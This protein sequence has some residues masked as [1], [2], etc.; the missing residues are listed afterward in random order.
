MKPGSVT[1]N[2]TPTPPVNT[3]N[4]QSTSPLVSKERG[5]RGGREGGEKVEGEREVGI[6]SHPQASKM[7]RGEDLQEARGAFIKRQNRDSHTETGE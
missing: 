5:G 4:P 3:A 6:P 2:K 1:A 7:T